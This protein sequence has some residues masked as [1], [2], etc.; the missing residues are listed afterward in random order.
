MNWDGQF[1]N[2]SRRVLTVNELRA[3]LGPAFRIFTEF[4]CLINALARVRV[5]QKSVYD[6]AWSGGPVLFSGSRKAAFLSLWQQD[7]LSRA[8]AASDRF[9]TFL[10]RAAV[11]DVMAAPDDESLRFWCHCERYR[12]Q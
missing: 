10:R 8:P 7:L 5:A 4:A 2:P 3:L 12:R 11:G 6:L 1:V 9:M